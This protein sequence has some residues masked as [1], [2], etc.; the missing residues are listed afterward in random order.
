MTH[1]KIV[2]RPDGTRIKIIVSLYTDLARNETRWNNFGTLVCDPRKRKWREGKI[3]DHLASMQEVLEAQ[4]ELWE[5]LK[6]TL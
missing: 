5:M 1:E 2:K 6:P 4:L 3:S